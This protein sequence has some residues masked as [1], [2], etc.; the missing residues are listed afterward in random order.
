MHAP[1]ARL[2]VAVH[3][4]A[5]NRIE[6]PADVEA[7]RT[8]RRRVSQARTDG[9]PQ[10]PELNRAGLRPHVAGVEEKHRAEAAAQ[11]RADLLAQPDHAVAADRQ[12]RA[13]ERAH[14]IP[15]PAA[16]A[17]RAAEEVL[18]GERHVEYIE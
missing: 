13:A 8:D 1:A 18:L 16:D 2:L 3:Q 14:L 17:R 15:S 9:V 5:R 7:N 10:I 12:T 11:R 4:Q 6:L